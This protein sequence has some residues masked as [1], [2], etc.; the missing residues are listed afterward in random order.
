MG[1]G[2]VLYFWE[3]PQ[4]IAHYWAT[5]LILSAAS[6]LFQSASPASADSGA[7][8]FPLGLFVEKG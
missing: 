6:L 2:V 4:V 5:S 8:T 7:A 1:L 3:C